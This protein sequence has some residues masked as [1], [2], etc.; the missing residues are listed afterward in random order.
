MLKSRHTGTAAQQNPVE[1]TSP[2]ALLVVVLILA[3]I[4][5]AYGSWRGQW[6][7]AAL[8]A[9]ITALTAWGI[10]A[11]H[12]GLPGPE[13]SPA[14][15][16]PAAFSSDTPLCSCPQGRSTLTSPE[17]EAHNAVHA[18]AGSDSPSAWAGPPVVDRFAITGRLSH[19]GAPTGRL[20]L[21]LPADTDV[22]VASVIN[23]LLTT[24]HRI[25]DGTPGPERGLPQVEI[26]AVTRTEAAPT[27]I[28]ATGF[29]VHITN[30]PATRHSDIT[31]DPHQLPT[32]EYGRLLI[33][34]T[35]LGGAEH[36]LDDPDHSFRPFGPCR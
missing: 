6:V 28:P 14:A 19:G 5:A 26:T 2:T 29:T 12:R 24:G 30:D 8:H 15:P 33:A 7:A 20:S 31:I 16:E 27:T 9:V 10:H 32:P 21:V 34:A 11:R 18:T 22:T 36:L 3:L 35:L 25:L 13:R 23:V 4:G 17:P 1:T